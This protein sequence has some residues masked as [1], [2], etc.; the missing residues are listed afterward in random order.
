MYELL[1][2]GF[3]PRWEPPP[4]PPLPATGHHLWLI[5]PDLSPGAAEILSADERARAAKL[6]TETLRSRFIANRCALRHILAGYCGLPPA[7]IRFAYGPHGK[8]S[9]EAPTGQLE[10]NLSHSGNLALLAVSGGGAVGVDL[11][12]L[13]EVPNATELGRR[14]LSPEVVLQLERTPPEQRSARFLLAWTALEA[15]VKREGSAIF[16]AQ[17][18]GTNRGH[19]HHLT[20]LPGW[21][22]CI[23][24]GYPH[25]S[26]DWRY[27]RYSSLAG[28]AA[29]ISAY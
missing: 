21:L 7:E 4:H 13:R 26:G 11:E 17:P 25:H 16:Q 10:F 9:L 22:A 27:F 29:T 3:A 18:E 24:L 1:E 19:L 28:S 14:I 6:V 20:P 12:A 8:P 5:E 15:S 2:L 23:A